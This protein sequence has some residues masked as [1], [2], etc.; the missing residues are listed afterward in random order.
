V[1]NPPYDRNNNNVL[2][3]IIHKLLGGFIRWDGVYFLHVA[4]Y[5]Y[6]YENSLAFF[7]LFPWSV[8]ILANSL[9]WPLQFVIQYRTILILSGFLFN[10]FIHPP[11]SLWMIE[12]RT[13]LLFLSYGGLNTSGLWSGINKLKTN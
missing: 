7:P 12:S 8:R 5:G 3:S 11:S 6:I 1:F 10:L 9:F 4:E 13:L 2:D